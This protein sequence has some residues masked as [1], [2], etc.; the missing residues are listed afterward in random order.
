GCVTIMSIHKSK[1]LEFPVVFLCGLGREF[2][3]ESQRGAV[4]CH[5]EMGLGLAAVDSVNRLRY[6]TIAKRAIAAKIG[7]E[8]VSEEL[9]VLYVAMTRARDRLI[10][11]YASN[12]LEQ[13]ITYIV[14]HMD[15]DS[16]KL[17]IREAVCPGDWVLLAALNR[18]EAGELFALGGRPESLS[19]ETTPWNIRV[20]RAPALT[21][22]AQEDAATHRISLGELE[23]VRTG[24]SFRYAHLAA[25][26]APSKQ[27]ATQLKGRIKD[28][29]AAED[30]KQN[31]LA[32]Q[33]R[34]PGFVQSQ[35]GG[36]AYG[37]AIHAI[38]Q[39]ID[40]TVCTDTS[41][42]AAEVERL[43]S[44]RYLSG[45]QGELIHPEKI[46]AFFA[47]PLG[48]KVRTGQVE[49]EFKFSILE[50]AGLYDPA[51]SGEQILLQGV[52]DC[53]L[54]EEDGITIIDFKTDY[55]TDDTLE[56][57]TE[58]YRPQ[59]QAYAK[60]MERI[61]QRKVKQSLLYFFHMDR[62]QTV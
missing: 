38:M 60:A 22:Q 34:K 10:M 61:F 19:S 39:Y 7:S 53:A 5:K 32:R 51:L 6:P 23:Q 35:F 46:A 52:V 27:T 55:V 26:E 13:D 42:V 58:R 28:A 30:T 59:V 9:R 49:R 41:G 29:E 25:T 33:W 56:A 40:Y 8:S 12:R 21:E 44:Q 2:N 11:T 16:K 54:I 47:S 37:N 50:D 4:L 18:V 36:K 1:G 14:Q 62:F 17:L 24:L 15:K 48:Q 57:L 45:E 43:V 3:M 31:H 20:V